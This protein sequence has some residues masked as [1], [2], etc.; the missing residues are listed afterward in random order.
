MYLFIAGNSPTLRPFER[1]LF[2]SILLLKTKIKIQPDH[3][4]LLISLEKET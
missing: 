2:F 4:V 3:L 1:K